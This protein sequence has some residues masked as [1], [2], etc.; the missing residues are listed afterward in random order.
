[1]WLNLVASHFRATYPQKLCFIMS[2][3]ILNLWSVAATFNTYS[4]YS[5]SRMLFEPCESVV[6]IN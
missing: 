5:F 3:L 2:F 4:S 1:M 6:I